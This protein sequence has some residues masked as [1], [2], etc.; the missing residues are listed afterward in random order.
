MSESQT[1][2]PLKREMVSDHRRVLVRCSQD[3][4]ALAL[5]LIS[6]NYAFQK[7]NVV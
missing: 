4:C 1:A 2:E 3:S 7:E 5:G 6:L